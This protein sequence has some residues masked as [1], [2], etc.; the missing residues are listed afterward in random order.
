MAGKR[1][2]R[3]TAEEGG[4][5]GE[6]RPLSMPGGVNPDDRSHTSCR[7]E[8]CELADSG[9]QFEGEHTVF[10]CPRCNYSTVEEAEAFRL[11]PELA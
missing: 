7:P 3:R 10:R 4:P 2:A 9:E 5:E 1:K 6:D 11:N 8:N